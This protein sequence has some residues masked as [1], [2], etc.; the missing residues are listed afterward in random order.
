MSEIILHWGLTAAQM[1][2][3]LAMAFAAYR[4]VIGPRAQDRVLAL[5]AFYVAAMLMLMLFGIR[6]GSAIYFEV[7]LIIGILGFVGTVALAKFLM[8]G[9]VIE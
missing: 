1:I 8:R 7:A 6:V 2:I 4:I 9:E 5:D 3:A